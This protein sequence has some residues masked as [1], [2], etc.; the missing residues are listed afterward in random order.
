VYDPVSRGAHAYRR[1]ARELV[2]AERGL[3][4]SGDAIDAS[5]GDG[6]TRGV[7]PAEGAGDGTQTGGGPAERAD[8][9]ADHAGGGPY[10][11]H[12]AERHATAERIGERT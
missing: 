5:A 3:L 8:G 9:A 6:A 10:E 12:R 1:L 11:D 4:D 2:D 7:E